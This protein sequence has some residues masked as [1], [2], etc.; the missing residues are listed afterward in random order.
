MIFMMY[1]YLKGMSS[2]INIS[3]RPTQNAEKRSV[4]ASINPE[5]EGNYRGNVACE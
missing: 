4:W 3:R 1:L 2:H 5:A